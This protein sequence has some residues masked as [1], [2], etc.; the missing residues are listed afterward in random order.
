M[1]KYLE[2]KKQAFN[3]F[4]EILKSETEIGENLERAELKFEIKQRADNSALTF[5]NEWLEIRAKGYFYTINAT[6]NSQWANEKQLVATLCFED[7]IQGLL[8]KE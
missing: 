3:R 4:A 7:E 1:T 8:G 6:G 2:I 5:T